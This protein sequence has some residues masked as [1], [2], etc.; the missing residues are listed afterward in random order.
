MSSSHQF[1]PIRPFTRPLKGQTVTPPGSKSITNRALLLAAL[2]QHPVTLEGALFSRDT[3][4]MTDCLHR[5][6]FQVDTDE[7]A[8]TIRVYGKGGYIP[9]AKAELHMGN[10]GTAARFVTAF[11][12]LHTEGHFYVDG[13]TAMRERPM[14]GLLE[15]IQANGAADVTYHEKN[16]HMPF[17]LHTHG[18]QGGGVEIDASASSQ[19]LSALLMVAPFAQQTSEI[20]LKGDTVSRPFVD[21][22]LRMMCQ[23]GFSEYTASE[24]GS[25][26]KISATRTPYNYQMQ[27]PGNVYRV[28]PDA[29]A[30]SYFLA[31]P[32]VVGGT[33]RV[34]LP[35]DSLQGDTAF[36]EVLTAHGHDLKASN[37]LTLV[38][39][40]SRQSF[41]GIDADFNAI[42]DT[43]LT[44]AAI[45]PLLNGPTTIRGI[46]HTR[47]QET[48]RIRAM[49]TEL[50]RLGQDVKEGED[51]IRITPRPLV[52]ATIET[53]EDH[54]VAMSFG[55]LGCYDLHGDGTPWLTIKDPDCCRKTYPLFFD[56]LNNLHSDTHR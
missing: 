38:S 5:L 4:I 31:L 52:P 2:N 33:L 25:R 47:A 20:I 50:K 34:G 7:M 29:T 18:L 27:T 54:R 30:A 36:A 53:Y 21:M 24:Q 37:G 26:F 22:T 11:L 48:D 15:A 8:C 9:N 3:R 51:W 56:V 40:E 44:L 41:S 43:F 49:A 23:Y 55:I 42:S 17:T 14:R 12:C 6:G 19:M 46:G 45:A 32:S 16:G 13:D 35:A 1:L 10:A 28:E 39:N